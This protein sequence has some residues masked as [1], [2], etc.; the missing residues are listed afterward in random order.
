MT[1]I[2][3]IFTIYATYIIKKISMFRNNINNILLLVL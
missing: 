2:E 1:N 3:N